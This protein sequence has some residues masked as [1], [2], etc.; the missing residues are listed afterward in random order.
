M[1]YRYRKTYSLSSKISKS[2]REENYNADGKYCSRDSCKGTVEAEKTQGIVWIWV[3][4]RTSESF[5]KE[6]VPREECVLIRCR[7]GQLRMRLKY[8][9]RLTGPRALG[10]T[11]AWS[12]T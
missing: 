9:Y 4:G 7:R 1:L 6:L 3:E 10:E 12:P 8:V 5:L 2:S 11:Q